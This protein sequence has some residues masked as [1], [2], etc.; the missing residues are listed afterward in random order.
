MSHPSGGLYKA[1]Q[2]DG[3]ITMFSA[4][5]TASEQQLKSKPKQAK[6]RSSQDTKLSREGSLST[7]N[8][9]MQ[10]RPERDNH[11]QEG[12]SQEQASSEGIDKRSKLR[13]FLNKSPHHP[14]TAESA[15]DASQDALPKVAPAA[16]RSDYDDSVDSRES[17]SALSA[18]DVWLAKGVPSA[19]HGHV[20]DDL[21]AHRS[22]GGHR[23]GEEIVQQRD[24]TSL[25]PAPDGDP[26]VFAQHTRDQSLQVNYTAKDVKGMATEIYEG[27][28]ADVHLSLFAYW[29]KQKSENY[30]LA[31]KVIRELSLDQVCAED[32]CCYSASLT[33][34]NRATMLI[35]FRTCICDSY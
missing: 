23:A 29:I 15:T 4:M 19:T 30:A 14:Q 33:G 25:S 35:G 11:L 26:R 24:Q 16:A 9:S 10:H 2:A 12:G 13:K 20:R 21:V 5:Y 6:E 18:T 27:T 28:I 17:V 31:C 32:Y 8:S 34:N 22:E 3:L 1:D 7:R